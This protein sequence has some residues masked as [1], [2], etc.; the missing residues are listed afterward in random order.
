MCE[1]E[2]KVRLVRKKKGIVKVDDLFFCSQLLAELNLHS[3]AEHKPP[4][5][6]PRA[7]TATLL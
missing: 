1:K 2:R 3:S 7:V 5:E 6:Y 4:F